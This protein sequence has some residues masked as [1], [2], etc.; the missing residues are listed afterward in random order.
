MPPAGDRQRKRPSPARGSEKLPR[1]GGAGRALK[2]EGPGREAGGGRRQE[3]LQV[4]GGQLRRAGQRPIRAAEQSVLCGGRVGGTEGR[5]LVGM[6]VLT[7][8]GQN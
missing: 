1:G 4:E 8:R 5:R 3:G 6:E 2:G 7:G